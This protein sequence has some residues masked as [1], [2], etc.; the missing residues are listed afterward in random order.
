MTF[1]KPSLLRN[2]LVAFIG[3]GFALGAVFPFFAG[4]FV[5]PLPGMLTWFL[6]SCLAAGTVIG[7]VNFYLTKVILLKRLERMSEIAEAISKNDISHHCN[8]VS[9]DMI[10]GIVNSFNGMTQNLRDMIGRI[11]TS[12]ETLDETGNRLHQISTQFNTGTRE[13]RDQAQQAALAIEE[14]MAAVNH[15]AEMASQTAQ[16]TASAN[17]QSRH[18]AYIAT[19]AIGAITQLSSEVI[20]AGDTIRSLESSSDQIGVVLD[21]IRGIAEQTNL[22]ALNAAIEAAR[23]GEQG[24]GFAVVADEVRTLASRTQQSTEEIE[25]M[26]SDLQHR[27]RDAAKVMERAQGQVGSTEARFEEAAEL[28]A[29]ISGAISEVNTMNREIADAADTQQSLAAGVGS[30]IQRISEV[31]ERSM[32]GADNAEQEIQT[33]ST[34]IRELRNVVNLFNR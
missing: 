34:Q 6:I 20:K 16:S 25:K 3:F 13:Q 23:A 24:R 4:I 2:L 17:E 26:I 7:L 5:T 22:L 9:H 10:G 15:A 11:D 12:S 33:I 8:M 28:L 30:S 31:T 14:M 21:V 1:R 29:E 27:T 19:E 32:A 18:G